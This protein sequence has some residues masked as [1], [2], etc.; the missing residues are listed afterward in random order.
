MKS[1]VVYYS[2]SGN[3]KLVAE[4]I[5]REGNADILELKV[6]KA[7]PT[8]KVGKILWAGKTVFTTKFPKLEKFDISFD[9]Y[10]LIFF[11]TPVWAFTY[12]PPFNSFFRDI[13]IKDKQIAVFCTHGGLKGKVF[14]KM[15]SKLNDNTIVGCIDFAEPFDKFKQK[16]IQDAIVWTK[17]ILDN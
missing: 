2:F 16:Y 12:A 14:E 3:T 10:D 8:N 9:E 13:R 1:L 5:A 4:A 11:G 17:E 6:A 15:K 7:P